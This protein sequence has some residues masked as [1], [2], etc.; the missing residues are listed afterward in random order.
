MISFNY[1]LSAR[2][3]LCAKFNSEWY[4]NEFSLITVEVISRILITQ[5]AF[6]CSTAMLL[7]ICHEPVQLSSLY[8]KG[9]ITL[10]DCVGMRPAICL[11]GVASSDALQLLQNFTSVQAYVTIV[12]YRRLQKYKGSCC[13]RRLRTASC[14]EEIPCSQLCSTACCAYRCH[15]CYPYSLPCST[16]NFSIL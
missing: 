3:V 13:W 7:K 15:L 1:C 16:N 2:A 11:F 9:V 12:V 5:A 4:V 14:S 8:I 6:F 10:N